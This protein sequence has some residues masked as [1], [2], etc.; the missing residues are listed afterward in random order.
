MGTGLVP[1]E[2]IC[3]GSGQNVIERSVRCVA[4]LCPDT[5]PVVDES[6]TWSARYNGTYVIAQSTFLSRISGSNNM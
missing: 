3:L 4:A 2:G 1:F 6:P 5:T